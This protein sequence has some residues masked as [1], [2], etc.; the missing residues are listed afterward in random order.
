[1]FNYDAAPNKFTPDSTSQADCE[2][3]CHVAVKA[4]NCILR[5]TASSSGLTFSIGADASPGLAASKAVPRTVTTRIGPSS[6]TIAST[7]PEAIEV[8]IELAERTDDG[9]LTGSGVLV[10]GSV[11]TAGEARNLL[12][13]Q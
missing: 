6:S 2:N 8:A 11:V 7:L 1:M 3:S 4:T 5:L 10:I 12:G 13:A 9:V